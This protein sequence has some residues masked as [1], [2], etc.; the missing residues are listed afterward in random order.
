MTI[1]K[2]HLTVLQNVE[3]AFQKS[4]YDLYPQVVVVTKQQS[5]E[6]ISKLYAL[7]YRHF[8]ENR[9]EN[10]LNRQM[11]LPYS[12]IVWHLIG[13]LQSRKVKSIINHVDYIHSIDRDS[14]IDEIEKRAVRP[15]NCFLQINLFDEP[16]KHGF[17]I[18][19]IESILMKISQYK[20][21]TIVGFMVMAPF[22]ENPQIIASQF[23]KMKKIQKFYE[24]KGIKNCPCHYLSMG[25][26][27]DY[28]L[29]IQFGATHVRIGSAFFMK[30]DY[31]I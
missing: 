29:A 3:N 23:E 20:M 13:T 15:K 14:L 25:M 17:K 1:L 22:N 4:E 31:G 7:G 16:Q 2:N 21:I 27:Q 26:S 18:N 28:E 8:A 9:V 6:D 30:S 19:E 10:L 5:L 12:D 11:E 24:E